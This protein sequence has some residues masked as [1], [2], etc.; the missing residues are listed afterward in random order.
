MKSLKVPLMGWPK[1]QFQP[2]LPRVTQLRLQHTYRHY[3]KIDEAVTKTENMLRRKMISAMIWMFNVPSVLS[4]GNLIAHIAR[5]TLIWIRMNNICYIKRN[6]IW[7]QPLIVIRWAGQTFYFN[8]IP[9]SSHPHFYSHSKQIL[10]LFRKPLCTSES[11]EL[12]N[13]NA[14]HP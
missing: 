9:I 5:I 1:T 7:I 2:G 11:E 13:W 10:I 12:N 8:G 4:L 14:W 6:L 3:R